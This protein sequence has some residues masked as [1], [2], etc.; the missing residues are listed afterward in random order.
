MDAWFLVDRRRILAE[1]NAV[2]QLA[3]GSDWLTVTRWHTLGGRLHCDA[4]ISAHGQAYPVRLTYPDHF[5]DVAPW[6][7]PI[8]DDRRW[9]GHQFGKG[10]VLCLE[11]RPDN[12]EPHHL[13]AELLTST[14][15]L[16][17]TENPLGDPS[18]EA[19][20]VES[21]HVASLVEDLR[22]QRMNDKPMLFISAAMREKLST[23]S[24]DTSIVTTT[25]TS[26]SG[27]I[28]LQ[29]ADD[30]RDDSVPDAGR[31]PG[32]RTASGIAVTTFNP[33]TGKNS[34]VARL[35]KSKKDYV[36]ISPSSGVFLSSVL[37]DPGQPSAEPEVLHFVP[38]NRAEKRLEHTLQ[39][40]ARVGIVGLGSLGSKVAMSLARSGVKQFLL[41]D[42]DLLLPGNL[43]RHTLDWRHVGADKV[44]GMATAIRDVQPGAEVDTRSIEIAGQ[45]SARAHAQAIE[46]VGTCSVIIEAT[47]EGQ[48]FNLLSAISRRE[49]IPMLWGMVY[50][51]GLGGFV[52]RS[53]PGI[54]ACPQRMRKAYHDFCEENPVEPDQHPTADYEAPG[55][56]GGPP[57]TAS[58]ADVAIIAHHLAQMALD[59]F[60]E[61]EET[62]FPHSMYLLGF[63]KGW[64]F[65]QPFHTFP[66][67]LPG[68][69]DLEATQ[70]VELTSEE[71]EATA[72]FLK[73]LPASRE[74]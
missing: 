67:M 61:G 50:G 44:K 34:V 69:E 25:A 30:W 6:V 1:V 32:W 68:P 49:R 37:S 5:P 36:H 35:D 53:R 48:V 54:D 65:E 60:T 73:S 57:L 23:M 62:T 19:Q 52:A 26:S 39:Q 45:G 22:R 74:T 46:A 38:D 28:I 58:D 16:L 64:V 4:E 10:G 51:G 3:E 55:A 12:W 17:S 66:L 43:V 18:I 2:K 47:T 71:V 27:L 33:E 8:D 9:S 24:A 56:S 40:G 20:E 14:Y 21:G 70:E 11:L 15:S 41:I 13:G 31:N 72:A 63:R 42:G 59:L 29:G 7:A